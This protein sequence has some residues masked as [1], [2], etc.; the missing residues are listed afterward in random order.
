MP[1]KHPIPIVVISANEGDGCNDYITCS[2]ELRDTQQYDM[3]E[4]PKGRQPDIVYNFMIGGDGNIYEARGWNVQSYHESADMVLGI[5]FVGDYHYENL[6]LNENQIN[7]AQELIKY[8]VEIRKIDKNYTLIAHNQIHDTTGPG[9]N[10]L[11]EIRKWPHWDPTFH[12][13]PNK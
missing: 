12:I 9:G 6:E 7:A 13:V 5:S 3:F 8:G 4:R 1:L 10:V 2:Q 11:K